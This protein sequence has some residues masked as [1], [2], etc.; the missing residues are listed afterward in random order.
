MRTLLLA[1]ALDEQGTDTFVQLKGE[2][3]RR[4]LTQLEDAD[5]ILLTTPQEH[6]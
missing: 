1:L 4:T 6:A 3:S 2:R 5:S